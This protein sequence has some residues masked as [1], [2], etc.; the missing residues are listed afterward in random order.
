VR[1]PDVL[2]FEGVGR[3]KRIPEIYRLLQVEP[4]LGLRIGEPGKA[5]SSVGAIPFQGREAAAASGCVAII[6]FVVA[7]QLTAE[8]SGSATVMSRGKQ[9]QSAR[10]G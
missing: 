9:P 7:A 1:G 10:C 4:E 8:P 6:E 2:E 5:N 3:V